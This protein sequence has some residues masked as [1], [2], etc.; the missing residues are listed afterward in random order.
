MLPGSGYGTF[1]FITGGYGP[2]IGV[3]SRAAGKHR[4]HHYRYQA[5]K[6]LPVILEVNLSNQ[7]R[8]KKVIYF[9]EDEEDIEILLLM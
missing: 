6:E 3:V 8:L 1:N 5:R 2:S 9:P 7:I 4:K